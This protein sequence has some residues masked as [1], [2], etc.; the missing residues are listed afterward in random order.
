MLSL[1]PHHSFPLASVPKFL[2]SSTVEDT[3]TQAVLASPMFTA[4]WR[5]N[6]NRSLAVLRFRGCKAKSPPIQRMEADDL[7]AAIFPNQAACQEN[8][9]YPIEIPDHPL[10]RQTMHDCLHEAMDVA[11]LQRLLRGFEEGSVRTHFVDTSEAS[12]LAYEILNGRPFTFLDDAPLEE[13]RTRAVTLRRGLP[14]EARELGRLDPEAI[15]RVREEARPDPRDAEE[16]HDWLLRLIVMPPAPALPEGVRSAGRERKSAP[17]RLH[18]RVHGREHSAPRLVR[19]RA[20]GRG[21]DV[22]SRCGVRLGE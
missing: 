2:S 14:V 7:M 16:L 9:S 5:W 4:R 3:L 8:V 21:Q 10:V 19:E 22:V 15:A 17:H 11:G 12:P 20:A 1:G 18:I 13:R 6:L